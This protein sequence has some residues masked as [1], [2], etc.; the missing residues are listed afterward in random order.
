MFLEALDRQVKVGFIG[1]EGQAAVQWE[2]NT[3]L[4]KRDG[5]NIFDE[6]VRRRGKG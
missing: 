3:W 2:K 5:E 4:R 6:S 1:A